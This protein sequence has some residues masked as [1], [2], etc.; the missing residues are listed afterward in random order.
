MPLTIQL[1]VR[2][3]QAA[4]NLR[5]WDEILADAHYAKLDGTFETDRFGHVI[6][7]PPPSLRHGRL[8]RRIATL[9]HDQAR[10]GDVVTECPVSTPD[11]VKGVDVVWL[12]SEQLAKAQDLACVPFAPALCVEVKSPANSWEELNE[13]KALYFASGATEVWICDDAGT[14]HFF[15]AETPVE[16]LEISTFFPGFPR[17]VELT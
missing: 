5:R 2:P 11:G 8:Q 16:T 9:L 3:D 6:H 10:E 15:S 4:F 1:P 14:M 7:M 13:K 17:V 12:S